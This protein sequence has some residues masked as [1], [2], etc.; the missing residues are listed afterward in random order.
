MQ[1]SKR[2]GDVQIEMRTLQLGTANSLF[3]GVRPRKDGHFERPFVLVYMICI[4][5]G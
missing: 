1:I 3:L 2:E 5:H 4:G